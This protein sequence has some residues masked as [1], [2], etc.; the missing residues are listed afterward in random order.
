[1]S[2]HRK[3]YKE[4]SSIRKRISVKTNKSTISAADR[5]RHYLLV[6]QMIDVIFREMNSLPAD[7]PLVIIE[8]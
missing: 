6:K 8:A 5:A 1:M 7:G 2:S 4:I 3:M